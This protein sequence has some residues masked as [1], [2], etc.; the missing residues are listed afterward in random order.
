[1]PI[2]KSALIEALALKTR[3]PIGSAEAIVNRIFDAMGEAMLRGEGVEI[4]GFGS[5]TIREYGAYE[6]RNPRT[7]QTVRVRKKRLPFFKVGR[8]LK[9]RVNTHASPPILKTSQRAPAS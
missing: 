2:T 9:E 6:G 7:G 3:L 5:F 4:R 1:M 8:E